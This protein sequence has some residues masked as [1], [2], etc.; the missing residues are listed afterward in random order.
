MIPKDKE[1]EINRMMIEEND[2]HL[3]IRNVTFK[4]LVP[5]FLNNVKIQE[6]LNQR[7]PC[8]EMRIQKMMQI[9]SFGRIIKK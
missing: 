9:E 1:E 4:F 6:N 5:K 2:L 7:L 3:D 8:M